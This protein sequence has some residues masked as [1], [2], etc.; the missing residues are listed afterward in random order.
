MKMNEDRDWLLTKANEEDHCIIAV[1]GLA[2]RVVAEEHE[3]ELSEA[4]RHKFVS[5]TER[6]RNETLP[7]RAART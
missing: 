7:E 3:A 6:M 5:E 2:C 4:T 1:G